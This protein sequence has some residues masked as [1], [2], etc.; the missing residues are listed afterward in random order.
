MKHMIP[1]PCLL[2][3]SALGHAEEADVEIVQTLSLR[4]CRALGGSIGLRQIAFLVDGESGEAVVRRISQYHENWLR[5][6]DLLGRIALSPEVRGNASSICGFEPSGGSHPVKSVGQVDAGPLFL[7]C[8]RTARRATGGAGRSAD[9]SPRTAPANLK[10]EHA[11][12]RGMLYLLRRERVAA[13]LA[14]RSR[15]RSSTSTR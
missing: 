2:D 14:K 3:D 13:L 8:R 7:G 4:L 9:A 6:L 5:L 11:L 12:H 15:D 1:L 10:A